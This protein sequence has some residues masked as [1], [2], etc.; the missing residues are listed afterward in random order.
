MLDMFELG[1]TEYNCP[2]KLDI[3]ANN[4]PVLSFTGSGWTEKKEL[5]RLR[6][7]MTDIFSGEKAD[8][9]M[10]KGFE[11]VLNFEIAN[12]LDEVTINCYK[13]ELKNSGTNLPRVNLEDTKFSI[14][15]A[16]RRSNLGNAELWKKSMKKPKESSI[17]QIKPKAKKNKDYDLL[18][19]EYGR[20]HLE[21]QDYN[22]MT[23]YKPKALKRKLPT[24]P[25]GGNDL[26]SDGEGKNS[27]MED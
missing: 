13:I 19:N 25:E 5:E 3:S 17:G 9:V 12:T 20:L 26:G 1:I 18:G 4:K 16:I 21:K 14:K 7:I 24:E 8:A 22:S 27:R 15:L 6:N 11:H 23:L 2:D 10:L